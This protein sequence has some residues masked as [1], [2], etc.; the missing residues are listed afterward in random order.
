[1][2]LGKEKIH[3]ILPQREPFIMIDSLLEHDETSTTT[4]LTVD[5]DNLMVSNGF[6]SA[7]GHLENLA[8]TAAAYLGYTAYINGQPAPLGFIASVKN[9]NVIERAKVN[10]TIISRI[11]YQS[12]IL[13]IHI[14]KATCVCNGKEINNAELRIFIQE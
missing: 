8:Q 12:A 11:E 9:Y 7:A 3:L 4:Q 14:V 2:I 1:M 10:E 13:N 6:F 5:A